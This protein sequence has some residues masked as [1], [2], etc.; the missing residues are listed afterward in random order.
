MNKLYNSNENSNE[1]SL[2]DNTYILFYSCFGIIALIV[3]LSKLYY[4]TLLSLFI[5]LCVKLDIYIR[6]LLKKIKTN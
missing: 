1:N 4:C 6:K 2:N 3:L 5:F